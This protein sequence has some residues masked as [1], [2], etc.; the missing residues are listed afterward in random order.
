MEVPGNNKEQRE[1]V[2]VGLY[3]KEII[4]RQSDEREKNMPG[5]LSEPTTKRKNLCGIHVW[6]NT[7]NSVIV[8][9][10]DRNRRCSYI[11]VDL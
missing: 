6:S 3:I 1:R 10:S 2:F 7:G 8:I 11:T 5:Y 4:L 9:L